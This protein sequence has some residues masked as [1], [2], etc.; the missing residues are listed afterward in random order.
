MSDF[1]DNDYYRD[2]RGNEIF[3]GVVV[4]FN[5]SGDVQFGTVVGFTKSK[6]KRW[7]GNGKYEM[8]PDI[9]VES[10][11]KPGRISRVKRPTSMVV[12]HDNTPI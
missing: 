6:R 10:Y 12:I 2:Y 8:L 3:K 1:N 7:V 4:A 9:L 5:Y 11:H